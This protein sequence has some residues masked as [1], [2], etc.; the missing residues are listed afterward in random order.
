MGSEVVKRRLLASLLL[1]SPGIIASGW[2]AV[3]RAAMAFLYESAPL[4]K[5]RVIRDIIYREE[6]HDSKHRLDLF[7]PDTHHWPILI[8]I[9]GGGL[10]SGD[11]SLRFAGKDVYGNIGRFYASQGVGVA[12]I[13]Y[14]L[15]PQVTWREQVADGAAAVAWA[16][17]HLG[18]SGANTNRL[19]V[20]GHSA[21]AQLATRLAVDPVW[22]EA[23]GLSPAIVSGVIAVS[24][25]GFDLADTQSYQLGARLPDY[26]ARFRCGD[27]TENWKRDAS[28]I[29]FISPSS[30]PFIIL[31]GTRERPCLQR[32]SQLLHEALQRQGI[33][34]QIVIVPGPNHC[35]IVLT[36]SRPDRTSAPAILRFMGCASPHEERLAV[37]Q[38]SQVS[39][40]RSNR[41]KIRPKTKMAIATSTPR[42]I[43]DATDAKG[44]AINCCPR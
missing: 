11:K 10:T 9:H 30:P 4:A 5:G 24:G 42:A 2:V 14:R 39:A 12:V 44:M 40:E 41:S 38:V 34:S 17:A 16:H 3:R 28:P 31:Y 21:G 43:V 35:R 22:L 26:E 25:A 32:Q 20:A 33:R 36:L 37:N 1:M 13:N 29:S 15:Q 19:F 6:S 23:F 18:S 8:F 7:V 27:L